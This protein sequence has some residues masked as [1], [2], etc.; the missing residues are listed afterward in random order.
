MSVDALYCAYAKRIVAKVT[1]VK[2]AE[3]TILYT[4][5]VIYCTYNM[6][7][8]HSYVLASLHALVLR[9]IRK[10]IQCTLIG[11]STTRSASRKGS[12]SVHPRILLVVRSQC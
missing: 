6:C 9:P 8:H 3:Y 5:P 12:R 2:Q 4:V 10:C 11:L 1:N 7:V